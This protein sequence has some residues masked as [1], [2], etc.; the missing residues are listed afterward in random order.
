VWIRLLLQPLWIRTVFWIGWIL[1]WA[2]ALAAYMR[3]DLGGNANPF[4]LP[5]LAIA[6]IAA[7]CLGVGAL[8]AVLETSRRNRYLRALDGT[9]TAGERAQAISAAFRG[10]VPDNPRVQAAARRVADLQLAAYRKNPQTYRVVYP[11]LSIVWVVLFGLSLRDPAPRVA[12]N[13]VQAALWI[14]LTF[15]IRL[16]WRRLE[17][18]V[19]LLRSAVAD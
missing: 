14:S 16:S 12:F 15:W 10:P 11:L 6:L 2:L 4:T 7:G 17:Q 13:G 18:R 19:E 9:V 3:W 8:C 1:L 5:M